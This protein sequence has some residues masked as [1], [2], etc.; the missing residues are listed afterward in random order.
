[1]LQEQL[2]RE[3]EES[4]NPKVSALKAQLVEVQLNFRKIQKDTPA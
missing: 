4:T 1:M 3:R 2:E